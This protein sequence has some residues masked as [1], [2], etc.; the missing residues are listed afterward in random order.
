MRNLLC[1]REQMVNSNWMI[2]TRSHDVGA[3]EKPNRIWITISL[4][5]RSG[6]S[7]QCYISF[8]F[9]LILVNFAA[10]CARV[11]ACARVYILHSYPT[12]R[13]QCTPFLRWAPLGVCECE[14]YMVARLFAVDWIF[15]QINRMQDG[16]WVERV[17]YFVLI[18]VS[19]LDSEISD[20]EK[21]IHS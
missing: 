12:E 18:L 15:I 7:P 1:G 21:R 2:Q 17:G 20:A 14:V 5:E 10:V 11:C 9:I 3:N 4:A 8:N 19:Y 6:E 16:V 13:I